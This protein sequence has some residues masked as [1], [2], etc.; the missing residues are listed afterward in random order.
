MFSSG[1]SDVT[2]VLSVAPDAGWCGL[3]SLPVQFFRV[4]DFKTLKV[5]RKA[6][7]LVLNVRRVTVQMRGTDNAALRSQMN[8]A[9]MSIPTNVVEGTSQQS[10]REYARFVRFA[11]NST[12]ELEYHLMVARDFRVISAASFESLTSQTIEV[13]KMLHGLLRALMT[14]GPRIARTKRPEVVN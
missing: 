1:R 6:H 9:A 3:K 8:R 12:A 11:L 14:A 10:S 2:R 4:S 7:A 13:R 5:W